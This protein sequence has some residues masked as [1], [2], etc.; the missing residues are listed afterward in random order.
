MKRTGKTLTLS[1]QLPTRQFGQQLFRDPHTIL[2]YSNVLDIKRAWRVKDFSCWIQEFGLEFTPM[3]EPTQFALDVQLSS[4]DIP[5]AGD[6]NNAGDNR[7]VG[8]GTLTYY[9]GNGQYKPQAGFTGSSRM[10]MNSEYWMMEDHVI[11]NKLTISS[12]AM[13]DAILEGITSGYSL[14]YVVNLEE[15]EITPIESI[16]FNIKGAAQDL[17]S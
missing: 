7:A 6:W 5:N 1:G 4:D 15:W 9:L 2:E 8:W 16:V 17:S 3:N 10:L 13:G 11:Q 12:Q 14:N